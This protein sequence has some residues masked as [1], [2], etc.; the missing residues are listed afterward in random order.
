MSHGTHDDDPETLPCY[1]HPGEQT[2]LHCIE[3]ERPICIDCAVAAPVG[4]KCPDCARTSRAARGVVPTQRLFRGISAAA[5]TAGLLGGILYFVNVPFLGIILAYFA[6]VATGEACRRA[7]GGYR[8]PALARAAA[9]AAAI[10]IA[11]LPV[12]D[13]VAGA[14]PAGMAWTV[15]AAAAA[16]YGAFTRAS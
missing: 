6:G 5:L 13:V 14:N 15:I 16:A 8:D 3:C 11:V 9:V 12:L 4:F 2:A 10:G 7:S 1:R